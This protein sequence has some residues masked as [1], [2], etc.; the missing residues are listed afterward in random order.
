MDYKALCGTEICFCSK[1]EL[2]GEAL[3][4]KSG[5][6]LLVLSY[7]SVKR[8][9][10]ELFIENLASQNEVTT[11]YS[12]CNNPTPQ[13]IKEAAAVLSGV[14]P[15]MIIALGGGSVIDLAKGVRNEFPV[16]KIDLIAIPTTFGT[17]SELTQWATVWDK[18]NSVKL[19][20]DA[21]FLK[22]DRAYI[23]SEFSHTIPKDL[24]LATTLDA[25][26]HAM[27]SYWS[28]HSNPLVK[29][30]A[31]AATKIIAENLPT[32]MEG[33]G[34]NP[35]EKLCEASVLSALSFSVTRTTACHAISYPLTLK[36]GIPHGIA[37][38]ITLNSVAEINK[39]TTT[40][41]TALLEI[42]LPFGGLKNWLDSLTKETNALKLSTYG[43]TAVDLPELAAMVFGNN[44]IGNNPKV[45]SESDVLE[46]LAACL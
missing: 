35:R 20:L 3:T 46:I 10:L 1:D 42:F 9:G 2:A 24:L 13:D 22:P 44:R 18:K 45:L 32:A 28:V 37:A 5:K 27:E 17:G 7:A 25:L 16:Y 23:I 14:A 11:F 40:N 26:C 4:F 12:S 39:S 36:F 6:I 30:L 38:A 34:V 43:V 19:S 29:Q 31:L 21:P 8:H 15:D 33:G 41:M